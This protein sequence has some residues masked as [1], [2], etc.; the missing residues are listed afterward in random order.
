ML[1]ASPHCWV[2]AVAALALPAVPATACQLAL[3]APLSAFDDS[4]YVLIGE[5][6][7]IAG[8]VASDDVVGGA[9]G[10]RVKITE[11]LH[12]PEPVTGLVDVFEYNLSAA[13]EALG[14]ARDDLARVYPPGTAVRVVARAATRIPRFAGNAT[15]LEAGPF[16]AHVLVGPIYRGEPL[17]APLRGVYD[18]ATPIDVDRYERID[19]ARFNWLW[20]EGL[21]EFELVKEL[22]RL[23]RVRG[24][25]AATPILRRIGH[26][27]ARREVDFP[28]LVARYIQD[29]DT[30]A[31]LITEIR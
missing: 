5:V 3:Q 27:P 14:I 23:E 15:R 6:T 22:L 13:C 16:N 2:A 28:A 31:R 7:E 8:P 18:F 19:A 1:R 9:F 21:V 4:W 20:Y 11:L 24:D 26:N 12:S 30:A 17:S 25:A 10:L 29:A